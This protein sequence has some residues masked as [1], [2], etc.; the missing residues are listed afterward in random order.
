MAD[1]RSRRPALDEAID[2]AVREM[3]N[4]EPRPG[5][6]RRVMARLDRP[7]RPPFAWPRLAITA[8][9]VA[10]I[11]VL[12]LVLRDG[13]VAPVPPDSGSVVSS[14]TPS[15]QPPRV[16]PVP[17]ITRPRP[18]TVQTNRTVPRPRRSPSDRAVAAASVDVDAAPMDE[19]LMGESPIAIVSALEPPRALAV[20]NIEQRP[21]NVPDIGMPAI[22]IAQLNVQPLQPPDDGRKE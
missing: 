19:A 12:A 15:A 4:V 16:A 6:E 5:F 17:T 9:V 10:A 3:T 21:V 11:V 1:D 20:E 8:G 22:D 2:R 14:E 18:S 7:A 13:R